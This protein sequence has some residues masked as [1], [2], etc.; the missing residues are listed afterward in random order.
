MHSAKHLEGGNLIALLLQLPPQLRV[1]LLVWHCRQG[2][3]GPSPALL[4]MVPL[5]IHPMARDQVS[6]KH[7]E[8]EW[9]LIAIIEPHCL[10]VRE[11]SW[12]AGH[13][14]LLALI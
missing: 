6:I 3:A 8:Q 10:N 12:R 1:L 2:S 11:N 5:R 9:S 13:L 7:T 14:R 4:Q